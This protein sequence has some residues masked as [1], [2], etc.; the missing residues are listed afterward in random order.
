MKTIEKMKNLENEWRTWSVATGNAENV[1]DWSH[2]EVRAFAIAEVQACRDQAGD[3]PDT[4]ET[5]QNESGVSDEAIA[6]VWEE[7]EEPEDDE[8]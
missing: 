5:F 6:W 7:T 2:E 4:W 8:E 1:T 3:E